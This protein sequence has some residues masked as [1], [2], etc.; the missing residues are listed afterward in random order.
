M[1][2]AASLLAIL[3]FFLLVVLEGGLIRMSRE[4]AKA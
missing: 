2:A 1:F 3:S 4:A